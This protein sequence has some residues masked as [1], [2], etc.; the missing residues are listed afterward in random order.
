MSSRS[1]SSGWGSASPIFVTPSYVTVASRT[2]TGPLGGIAAGRHE[3][4]ICRRCRPRS[5]DARGLRGAPAAELGA[6][7][8]AVFV[9]LHVAVQLLGRLDRHDV[10]AGVDEGRP[11]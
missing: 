9:L 10:D 2:H 7:G 11:P 6:G 4:P 5:F 1:A 8:A 3:R